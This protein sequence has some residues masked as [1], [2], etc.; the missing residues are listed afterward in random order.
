MRLQTPY[1]G[2]V[3]ISWLLTMVAL[4]LCALV[5]YHVPDSNYAIEGVAH[6]EDVDAKDAEGISAPPDHQRKDSVDA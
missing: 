2:E 1:L 6:I 4:P 5:L 3:L